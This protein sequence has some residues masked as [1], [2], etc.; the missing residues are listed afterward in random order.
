MGTEEGFLAWDSDDN[1]LYAYNGSTW[2][3]VGGASTTLQQAY[4][5]DG[6][7]SDAI[8]T[9][10]ATDGSLII[11]PIAGTNFQVAQVTSAPTTD[12]VAI[13]NAG[14][15][16]IT[17][18]VDG[19]SLTFVTGDGTDPTNNGLNFALTSGGTAATD[20]LNAINIGLTGT[21]GT[22][23]GINF[24]DNNFD[25]DINATT[26]LTIGIGGTNEIT[27]TGTN[28][29]PS[30][31]E[32]NSLG[33]ATLEWEEVF[34]GDDAG[35][36]FGLDQ[37]WSMVYDE[38]TDDRLELVTAGTTGMLIQTANATGTS[39]NLTTNSLSTGT[40]FLI[41][42]SANTLSTGT[43]LQAQST[44]TALTTA[45]DG[46]LGYFNWNPGAT[47]TASGDL[48]RINIG[49]S[50]N[51]TNVFNVTD[52][53]SSLFRVSETQIES[54]VP[55]AFTAAGDVNIAYDLVFTNQTASVID[56]YGPLTLRAGESFESNNLT[57]TSYLSGNIL[58]NTGATAGKVGIGANITPTSLL[59]VSDTGTGA[60]G[61]A[62]AIFDQDESQEILTASASGVTK[63][64][65]DQSG[66]VYLGALDV[67]TANTTG[68]CW[69][70]N[71]INGVTLKE[72]TDCNG[73]P[74]DLAENFGTSDTSIEAGDVVIS[75]G[76]A[77]IVSPKGLITSKAYIAKSGVAYDSKIV[78]V[79]S[80]APNQVYGED[81][82]FD[83]SENPKPVSLAGRVPTKVNL[84]NGP[85]VAGD[86]LTSSSTPG[87]AMKAI[88]PGIVVGQ[89]LED[90]N[91]ENPSEVGKIVVFINVG[92]ENP[93]PENAITREE[94]EA[95][96]F[97]TEQNQQLLEESQNWNTNTA[98]SSVQFGQV[99]TEDLFVTGI[100]A[101]N[102]LSL[103]ESLTIGNDLVIDNGNIDAITQPLNIQ[104]SGSQPL[105]FMAGKV[106][107]DTSG[108]MT[109]TGDLKVLGTLDAKKV[110][111]GQEVAGTA[112]I[113]AGA[114][115]V[116]ILNDNI[117]TDSLIFVTP[118]TATVDSIY[119]KSQIDGE[120]IIGF[121]EP[122]IPTSAD[123]KFNWWVVGISQ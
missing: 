6:D 17:N 55:H 46:F 61:K 2:Q 59:Y 87:V 115:E 64:V 37:D 103:S 38:T 45:G 30:T 74:T 89:A 83:P 72:I 7:G 27:L 10:D 109:V 25:T 101:L 19:L 120:A 11:K 102:S 5:N 43:L 18:E 106:S 63:F 3:N 41:D 79:V 34:V 70:D 100:A 8:I 108:N 13:T 52:N 81:G 44:S 94:I 97:I 32:G 76:Q 112:I 22:E 56:S 42:N 71:T 69:F 116:T 50:G 75:T 14:L 58:L 99:V 119:V 123:I 36:K 33:S 77:Q 73:T 67:E 107:I 51:V 105:N 93:T 117:K 1:I 62:L 80:T 98:T 110:T 49:S 40:G 53:G 31:A 21:S 65:L 88:E 4:S 121:D 9:L 29:S 122:E 95:L 90:F 57:L 66:K 26:D 104:A 28:L 20:V 92:Y 47:T 12:I 48:F 82:L 54:A 113:P 35:I 91:P 84:E 16:T 23:R 39:L 96:L 78:G 118:T 86:S 114:F 24:S 15:G 85:I 68:T 60:I 111:V